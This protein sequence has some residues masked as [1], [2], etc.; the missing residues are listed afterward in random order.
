VSALERSSSPAIDFLDKT[1]SK[2]AK[3]PHL[4]ISIIPIFPQLPIIPNSRDLLDIAN[5]I[6]IV[7]STCRQVDRRV[8]WHE[9]Q[10]RTISDGICLKARGKEHAAQYVEL[11]HYCHA[12]FDYLLQILPEPIRTNVDCIY[13]ST[14]L[15]SLD[16]SLRFASAF[17]DSIH[18]RWPINLHIWLKKVSTRRLHYGIPGSLN[19][20]GLERLSLA[21]PDQSVN[22]LNEEILAN[23]LSSELDNFMMKSTKSLLWAFGLDWEEAKIKEWLEGHFPNKPS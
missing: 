22:L 6:G 11:G 3:F 1:K 4:I 12:F 19:T 10:W 5:S 13:S 7:R 15:S 23:Q 17:F 9:N 16:I 8:P 20:L 2:W 14:I 21:C 18:F